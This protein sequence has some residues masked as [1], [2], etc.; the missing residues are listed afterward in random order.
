MSPRDPVPLLPCLPTSPGAA[1]SASTASS[2]GSRRGVHPRDR[3]STA[4]PARSTYRPQPPCVCR[5]SATSTQ[6]APQTRADL[7]RDAPRCRSQRGLLPRLQRV[8]HGLRADPFIGEDERVDTVV[9]PRRLRDR[10]P[11]DEQD[12][13]FEDLCRNIPFRVR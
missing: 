11:L 2:H 1:G 4:Y 10:L 7:L 8:T 12:I 13:F 6:G 9:Y 5:T 3:G